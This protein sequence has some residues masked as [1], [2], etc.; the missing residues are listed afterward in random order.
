MQDFL[1]AHELRHLRARA[2]HPQ[3]IG[4]IERMHRTLKEEVT[5][6]VE[7]SPGQLKAA[8]GRF[9]EYYNSQ[10]D[11]EA[12]QNVT[13]DDVW[14]GRREAILSRRR[15]LQIKTS[16]ARREHYRRWRGQCKDTGSGPPEVSLISC[17][18]LPHQR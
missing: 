10:R 3:T 13:P 9:V 15:T 6:V 1:R 2:H 5:L 18:L 4:K 17:P 7:M 11:H 8:I 16:V 14:F 12:L